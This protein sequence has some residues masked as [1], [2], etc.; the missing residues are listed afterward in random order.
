MDLAARRI[1]AR[2]VSLHDALDRIADPISP[3][4]KVQHELIVAGIFARLLQAGG[5][6][7]GA[8]VLYPIRRRVR[9]LHD[10]EVTELDV[11]AGRIDP[12]WR[13]AEDVLAGLRDLRVDRC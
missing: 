10:I 12:H 5:G 3:D 1:A 11:G 2:R 8:V 13:G 4:G 9:R 6:V 7:S